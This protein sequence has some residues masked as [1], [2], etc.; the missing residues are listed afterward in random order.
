T[1]NLTL[2]SNAFEGSSDDVGSYG[3]LLVTAPNLT[4]VGAGAGQTIIDASGLA[5]GRALAV[6]SGAGLTLKG[7]TVQGGTEM[8]QLFVFPGLNGGWGGGIF[9]DVNSS[10]EV[11][12]CQITGNTAMEGGGI[13]ASGHLTVNRTTISGNTALLDGGGFSAKGD[14]SMNACTV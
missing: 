3:N 13:L 6:R 4:I 7:L 9:A 14:V 2:P 10:L 8:S 5:R 1:Y 12:D 11:D